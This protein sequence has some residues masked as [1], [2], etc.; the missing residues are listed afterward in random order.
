MRGQPGEGLPDQRLSQRLL[1]HWAVASL[2]CVS[3]MTFS[4]K[5]GVRLVP[6]VRDGM[7]LRQGHPGRGCQVRTRGRKPLLP[8]WG[9]GWWR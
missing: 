5:R 7:Q 8:G 1:S 9:A 2:C 3:A 4:R 6:A